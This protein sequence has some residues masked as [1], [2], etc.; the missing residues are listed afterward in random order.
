M[1]DDRDALARQV[2]PVPDRA[3]PGTLAFWDNRAT[4]A[5]RDLRLR[6]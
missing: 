3:H 1:T 4:H 2:L 6:R 5:L